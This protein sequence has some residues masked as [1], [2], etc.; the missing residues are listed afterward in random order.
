MYNVHN[1][2]VTAIYMY[3]PLQPC[4]LDHLLE[5]VVYLTLSVAVLFLFPQE[6]YPLARQ[7]IHLY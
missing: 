6:D 1:Y 4:L 2:S 7:S 3:M 5:G